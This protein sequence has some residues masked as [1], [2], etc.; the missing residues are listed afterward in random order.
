MLNC[1][2]DPSYHTD[3]LI[4]R[5][6]RCSI[7]SRKKISTTNEEDEERKNRRDCFRFFS[8]FA[9]VV[10]FSRILYFHLPLVAEVRSIP[11][12]MTL[13]CAMARFQ[14]AAN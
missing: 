1:Q 2:P 10:H 8:S 9:F 7:A 4:P 5:E 14:S 13:D 11:A 6:N 3:S 12:G